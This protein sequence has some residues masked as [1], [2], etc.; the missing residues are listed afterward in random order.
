MLAAFLEPER[1]PAPAIP[2]AGLHS[3]L[4]SA[5]SLA[6]TPPVQGWSP[7][8]FLRRAVFAFFGILDGTEHN[9]DFV[10]QATA[11]APRKQVAVFCNTGGSLFDPAYKPSAFGQ[12]SRSLSAAYELVKAGFSKVQVLEGGL[13]AWIKEGRDVEQDA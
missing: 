6:R 8:K 7:V 4:L 2:R 1:S 13:A 3:A 11:A 9:P 10:K 12:Q 5:H